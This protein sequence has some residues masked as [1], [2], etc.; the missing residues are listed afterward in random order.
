MH[1]T[2]NRQNPER[3]S[4]QYIIINK[5]TEQRGENWKLQGKK[6]QVTHREIC[7]RVMADF[8]MEALKA[9]GLWR[10]TAH[11][12]KAMDAKLDYGSQKNFCHGWRKKENFPC[13]H[14]KRLHK[15]T[16]SSFL[17]SFNTMHWLFRKYVY[18]KYISD[19]N[20]IFHS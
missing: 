8:S 19:D 3:T 2:Q 4:S 13:F 18:G 7:I 17:A 15:C 14:V 6:P 1:R 10:K 16:S 5:Y 9:R 20:D 11:V 12:L